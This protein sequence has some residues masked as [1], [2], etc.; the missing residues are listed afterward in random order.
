MPRFNGPSITV[1]CAKCC[2]KGGVE[3]TYPDNLTDVV[4]PKF[5]VDL[6]DIEAYIEL[7]VI[8]SDKTQFEIPL[9]PFLPGITSLD[10]GGSRG[11]LSIDLVLV[12]QISGKADLHGGF[13]LKTPKGSFFEIDITKD[14]KTS[15]EL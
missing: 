8:V 11:G 6:Q 1:V 9:L 14:A 12:F 5:R 3:A 13:Y 2:T 15:Q 7:D 4:N 10:L